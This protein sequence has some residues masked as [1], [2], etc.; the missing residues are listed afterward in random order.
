VRD[1]SWCVREITRQL[2]SDPRSG[3]NRLES[4]PFVGLPVPGEIISGYFFQ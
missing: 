4:D 1:E 3:S 2:D